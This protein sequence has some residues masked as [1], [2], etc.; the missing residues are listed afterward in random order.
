MLLFTRTSDRR[1]CVTIAPQLIHCGESTTV[2]RK[3][4]PRLDPRPSSVILEARIVVTVCQLQRLL[5]KK[6][7]ECDKRSRPQ[8]IKSN[9]EVDGECYPRR[10][11]WTA[12]PDLIYYDNDIRSGTFSFS[13]ATVLVEILP[14]ELVS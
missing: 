5:Q 7:S 14:R 2:L 8:W 3:K 4:R 6:P 9:H 12:Q 10:T 13:L 1:L 11:G